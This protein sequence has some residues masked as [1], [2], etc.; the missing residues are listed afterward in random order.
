MAK[1]H[2]PVITYNKEE[3]FRRYN[4]VG[5]ILGDIL[6]VKLMGVDYFAFT[7]W[8]EIARY[9]GVTNLLMDLIERPEF[10]HKAVETDGYQSVLSSAAGR[11][12]S[13]HQWLFHHCPMYTDIYLVMILTAPG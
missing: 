8:D 1:L 9:R 6:P 11:S 2:N 13:G 7:P 5:D 12:G 10:M 4:L 3:T